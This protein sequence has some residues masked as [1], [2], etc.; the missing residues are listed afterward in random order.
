MVENL[1]ESFIF[2]DIYDDSPVATEFQKLGVKLFIVRWHFK[3]VS[4]SY[5]KDELIKLT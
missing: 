2:K 3:T 4:D 1:D 5:I